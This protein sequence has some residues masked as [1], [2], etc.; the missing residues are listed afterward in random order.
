LEKECFGNKGENNV[1]EYGRTAYLLFYTKK[2]VF[3][4]KALFENINVNQFVL[5]DVYNENVKFLNMNIYLN[6]NYFNFLKKICECGLP[7]LND[8]SQETKKNNLTLTTFL[9][10]NNMIYNKIISLLKPGN[11]DDGSIDEN[12]INFEENIEKQISNMNNFAQVYTNC[13]VEVDNFFNQNKEIEKKNNNFIYKRKLIKLYFN[14]VFGLM[15]P[16]YH[17]QGVLTKS[18][19]EELVIKILKTLI[20]IIKANKGYSLWILKQVEKNISLFTDILFRY[21]TT[22]NELNDMAKLIYEFF[23]ITF[24]CIYNYEKENLDMVGDMINY[25]MTNEKGK[26]VIVKEHRSIFMR[27]FK[28]N[29][30]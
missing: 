17:T 27:L 13:K 25:L 1:N 2:S 18:Q 7:L 9:A 6:A 28:K 29:I 24:D 12:I 23:D 10:K 20:N 26:I 3:R 5:N 16:V 4:N 30:L 15:F 14:Y 11:N 22:D 21:G 8:E 19:N